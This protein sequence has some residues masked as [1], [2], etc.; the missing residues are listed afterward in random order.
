M[1]KLK[2]ITKLFS[3]F[4]IFGLIAF[5][6]SCFVD[7]LY[8]KVTFMVNEEVYEEV[9]VEKGFALT[10]KQIPEA[11][12]LEGYAFEGWYNGEV[13]ID[14]ATVYN[15]D[16]TYVAKFTQVHT[17]SFSVEGE[18]VKEISV[19]DGEKV[20]VVEVPEDPSQKAHAF[21]GWFDG[22]AMFDEEA[23][24]TSSANYVA[25]FERSHY[26]VEF[27]NGD[28]VVEVLVKVGE[29]LV[30]SEE[31]NP[32]VENQYFAGWYAGEVLVEN[33][34]T[35]SSDLVAEARF[36]SA[37]SFNGTWANEEGDYFIIENGK[38]FGAEFNQ[39][40]QEFTFNPETGKLSY[41]SSGY[42]YDESWF[43]VTSS[44]IKY[45]HS[46]YDATYEEMA[47]DVVE[48]APV[49]ESAYEGTYRAD[50]SSI[51]EVIEGGIVT[52]FNGSKTIKGI[53]KE[54]EGK[55]VLSYMTSVYQGVKTVD[56]V[57]DEQGSMVIGSQIYVKN[58]TEFSYLYY[59]YS[60]P[61]FHFFTVNDQMI[62]TVKED[63]VYYYGSVEGVV[64]TGEIITVSYNEK[65]VTCKKVSDTTYEVAGSEKGTY[66]NGADQMVLNGF[67]D[68]VFTEGGEESQAIYTVNGAGHIVIGDKGYSIDQVAQSYQALVKDSVNN[69]KYV[70]SNNSKYTLVLDGFGGAT[71]HYESSYSDYDYKGKYSVS[72]S[73]ITI[74]DCYS[75]ANGK[76]TVEENGNVLVGDS[77]IYLL[78]GATFEDKS[79]E[80]DGV[81]GEDGSIVVASSSKS[82]KYNGQTYTLKYN[83]NGT[84]ATF[85][86]KHT[87][88]YEGWYEAEFTD[89]ITISKTAEGNLKVVYQ[90][91]TWDEYG[92]GPTYTTTTTEHA[93]YVASELDAFAGTWVG[94]NA[95]G[96]TVTIVIN[97]DGTG[98]YNDGA[99]TYTISGNKLSF[100][101]NYEDYSLNGD[102][103]TNKVSVMWTY[104]YSDMPEFDVVREAKEESNLDAFAGTWVGKNA[105][106]VTVTIVINGD[107]T[108]TYNGGEFTYTISGN[109]LSFTYN[110]E[111][112]SLNGD[113]S[114][115]TVE[116]QWTYDYS[117][118]PAYNVTR[119]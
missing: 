61:T 44:G 54:V 33:G 42:Y 76:W 41:K 63:G 35:V 58:P 75:Y 106:G 28:E 100:T 37:E 78:E 84:Q 50:Q 104:D 34:M 73:V 67:G 29:Q 52:K 92:E 103:S 108:G 1:F 68:V 62:V 17:I 86:I 82:V 40:G 69:G 81:Y 4:I 85:N 79:E 111:D 5:L 13:L 87:D 31:M 46:Y 7:T 53:I 110:Y 38:V 98:T 101:Y 64:A 83:Y 16:V 95:Y 32:V 3:L 70:L 99:F 91:Y 30:I 26:V 10:E 43:V 72:G 97:G 9:L 90:L 11:P 77:N 21:V 96:V 27:K 112:Y 117:D 45:V 71:L 47:E 89:V 113:P 57:F 118:M 14:K 12:V 94:K 102:P 59:S 65:E 36:V 22:E 25:K 66:R 19:K 74:S 51:I 88:S 24:V 93:P 48:V 80:M 114:T 23:K 55:V 105:Y 39:N 6:S 2:N 15:E 119:Q 49:S 107:G 116:V 115:G 109:K 20:D 56:V 8:Q 18:V 60:H